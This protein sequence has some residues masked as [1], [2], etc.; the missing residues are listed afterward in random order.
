MNFPKSIEL[1]EDQK[2]EFTDSKTFVSPYQVAQQVST[3]KFAKILYI[4]VDLVVMKMMERK[5]DFQLL[6]SEERMFLLSQSSIILFM[7][8]ITNP[9]SISVKSFEKF[10]FLIGETLLSLS[11]TKLRT[12]VLNLKENSVGFSLVLITNTK[13]KMH[14]EESKQNFLLKSGVCITETKLEI[15]PHQKLTEIIIINL[16]NWLLNLDSPYWAD[17]NLTGKLAII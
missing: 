7:E 6:L 14:G 2:F 9:R 12:S 11:S 5:K 13:L 17:G 1:S 8:S 15:F 4:S 16:L 10:K 3:Y